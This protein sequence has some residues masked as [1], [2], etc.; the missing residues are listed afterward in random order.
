MPQ[1]L[2]VL[3]RKDLTPAQQGVQAGHA[4]AEFYKTWREGLKN[5]WDNDTLVYVSVE[6]EVVL[7]LWLRKMKQHPGPIFYACFQEPDLNWTVTAIA[8][9]HNGNLFDKLPL[10]DPVTTLEQK[11]SE[12]ENS[13][14]EERMGEDL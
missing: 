2:F 1:K 4:V 6:N 11:I 14:F 5:L 9:L 12:L 10:W 7:L 3:I 13:L 8:C